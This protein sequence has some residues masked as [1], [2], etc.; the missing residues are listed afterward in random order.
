ME[1]STINVGSPFIAPTKEESKPNADSSTA[2]TDIAK[3]AIKAVLSTWTGQLFTLLGIHT[4]C[5]KI[6]DAWNGTNRSITKIALSALYHYYQKLHAIIL[7]I[8]NYEDAPNPQPSSDLT[9]DMGSEIADPKNLK[10]LMETLCKATNSNPVFE[11]LKDF[12]DPNRVYLRNKKSGDFLEMRF[13]TPQNASIDP[14]SFNPE[15]Y[16][17]I[18]NS[19]SLAIGS[20]SSCQVIDKLMQSKKKEALCYAILAILTLSMIAPNSELNW[21]TASAI[22]TGA[23]IYTLQSLK[24]K[25]FTEN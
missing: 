18:F 6:S 15:E 14:N 12:H 1:P 16:R 11:C 21:Q 19:L 3:T 25:K 17:D 9:H 22:F 20:Y 4:V 23:G 5:I 10:T 7:D 24:N 8:F 13:H 2:I